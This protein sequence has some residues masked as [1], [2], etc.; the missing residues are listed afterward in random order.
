MMKGEMKKVTPIVTIFIVLSLLFVIGPFTAVMASPGRIEEPGFETVANWTYSETEPEFTDGIRST[1]WKTQETYSYLF[2][3]TPPLDIAKNTYCQILQS[4]DFTSIDRISFDCYLGAD[5]SDYEA[6]MLVGA[7]QVWSQV[8]PESDPVTPTQYLHV[9]V[10]LSGYTGVQNF[11][12]QIYAVGNAPNSLMLCYFDNIKIWGSHSDTAWTTVCNSF[13]DST[14]HGYMYGEN[15]DAGTTKVGWY[16]GNDD[17]VET[18]TYASWG[19]GILNWSECD[20][21][22]YEGTAT[23]AGTW[24][25]VVLLQSEDMPA[26][27]GLAIADPDFVAD[28]SFIVDATAIPEFPE[29]MAAI[30]VAG[31][32]FG[33][34]WWMRKRRLRTKFSSQ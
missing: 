11:I 29:V 10:D 3:S 9:E 26:T 15:F 32:C 4:V 28:D 1:A 5:S 34:Y 17:W 33:I 21:R 7:V 24:H 25:A 30:G 2:S 27:Y 18:D 16:D 8:V 23:A 22:S 14:N 6:R 12:I 13:A 20:F 19:G 31:L